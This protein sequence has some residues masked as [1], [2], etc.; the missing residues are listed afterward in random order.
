MTAPLLPP[1]RRGAATLF[2]RAV[3]AVAIV[4]LLMPVAGGTPVAEPGSSTRGGHLVAA[5][6][7]GGGGTGAAGTD[8][9]ARSDRLWVSSPDDPALRLARLDPVLGPG[10]ATAEIT[11]DPQDPRQRWWGTGAALTDAS[12]RL[13]RAHPGAVKRLYAPHRGHG[14]RLNLLRLPLSAT[15]FS[16]RPWTWAWDGARG[17]PPRQQ[18]RA[19]R[20]VTGAI[21]PLVPH[22]RVVATPWTA[23]ASM[24]STGSVRGGALD[25][26]A[27]AD[28]GRLLLSQAGWL[29][30]H[31]V[32]LWAMTLGNE[33]GYSSDYGSMTM[34]DQQ[35]SALGAEVGPRLRDQRVGLWALDHNWADRQR[36]DAVLGAT[37]GGFDGAAFHCYG[38]R[39]DQM[40]GLSVPRMVTEC[41][42]STDGWA[43]TFAWDARNLVAGS[44]AAGSSGLMM[45]NLA[46]DEHHGPVDAGSRWGC[47]D[48]RGLLT[49]TPDGVRPEP[50]FYT[51]AHLARAASPGARVLASNADPGLSA[52]AFRNPD[53]SIGVFGHNATGSSQT[54]RINVLGRVDL[55]YTIRPGQLFTFRSR[56][57]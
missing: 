33:P 48:C 12:E 13:L 31:G 24:K 25:D 44:V 18:R 28:Y 21:D 40:A 35:M 27:V 23:P 20:L 14:A 41:T 45:W 57:A 30:R 29:A 55:A 43:G 6:R 42:G 36:L 53:G 46:L 56:A 37:P 15:D 22:L 34:S 17:A 5:T 54:V 19:V 4:A 10:P 49:V 11:V 52:A 26:G 47:K 3:L 2:L 39:P 32:P 38:G 8:T 1:A 16:P 50:E 51:L 7:S 9:A